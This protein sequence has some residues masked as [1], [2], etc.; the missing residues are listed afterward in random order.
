MEAVNIYNLVY[1]YLN[2]GE[3]CQEEIARGEGKY[4]EMA[5]SVED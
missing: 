2:M 1:Y 3:L 4:I 5:M